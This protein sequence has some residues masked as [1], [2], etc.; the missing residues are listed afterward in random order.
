MSDATSAR[1]LMAGFH[2]LEQH[3]WRWTERR[4]A[5]VLQPPPGSEQYGATLQLKLYVAAQSIQKLGS[6]TLAA[7]VEGVALA[8]EVFAKDGTYLYT[9]AVPALLF[10]GGLLP[11]AFSLDKALALSDSEFRELG[12]VVEEVSLVR[13]R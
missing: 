12:T 9:R 5:V 10:R 4:F 13:N 8:P 1:Q 11:V 6:I 2:N 3:R 7:Q